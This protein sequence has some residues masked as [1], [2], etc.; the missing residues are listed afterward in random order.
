MPTYSQVGHSRPTDE[1]LERLR[2]DLLTVTP[3]ETDEELEPV[4][5]AALEFELERLKKRLAVWQIFMKYMKD[6]AESWTEVRAALTQ[7]DFEQIVEICDGVSLRD[8]L[9]DEG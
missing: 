6:G 4:N 8:L 5:Y 1:G 3:L 9:F 7:S 2:R